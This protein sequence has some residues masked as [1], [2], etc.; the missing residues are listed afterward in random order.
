MVGSMYS[1]EHHFCE[2]RYRDLLDRLR[3]LTERVE[4]VEKHQRTIVDILR[5]FRDLLRLATT[6]VRELD[7]SVRER[8]ARLIPFAERRESVARHLRN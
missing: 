1:D 4:R 5:D 6:R 8:S 7:R 2:L 3:D